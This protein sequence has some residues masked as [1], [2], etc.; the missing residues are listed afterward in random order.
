LADKSIWVTLDSGTE[1]LVRWIE[2]PFID[3]KNGTIR[4]KLDE[5]MRP[6]LLEIK[7]HFT[8][9]NIYF[10]L[11]MKSKYSIRLYEILKSYEYVHECSFNVDQLKRMLSAEKYELYKDFRVKVL[12][13]ALREIN[14]LS[15]I[16]VEY[17]AEKN[18]RKYEKI[19]FRISPKKDTLERVRTYKK[20]EQKLNKNQQDDG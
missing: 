5:L 8:A 3:H 6:F 7:N 15:D 2:R 4:I 1:T 12:D 19:R 14:E 18:G 11:A 17:T 9:Y 16:S 13:I 10:T 20:V